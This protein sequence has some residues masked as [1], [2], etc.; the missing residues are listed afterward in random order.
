MVEARFIADFVFKGAR[1]MKAIR[2]LSLALTLALA[3]AGGAT[4]GFITY[5]FDATVTT[6]VDYSP[7]H[8]LV[9]A[10]IRPNVS[11][12]VGSFTFD[13]AAPGSPYPKGSALDLSATITVDGKYT[14]TL[15]SPNFFDSIDLLGT[16]S[17]LYKHGNATTSFGAPVGL[18]ELFN[19]ISSTN[20]LSTT[21]FTLPPP[22][23]ASATAGISDAGSGQPYYYIGGQVV[24]LTPAAVPEPASLTMLGIGLAGLAVY[25]R[26]HRK[27]ATA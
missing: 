8:T 13:N 16:S 18:L 12:M 15:T 9:P 1:S 3:N 2:F 21:Q 20:A 17:G 24:S 14:Y 6:V 5:D 10:S 11:T 25:R 27:P 26:R 19:L 7:N 22:G 4:A 23:P